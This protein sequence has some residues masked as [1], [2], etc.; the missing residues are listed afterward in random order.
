M[1]FEVEEGNFSE[2][3]FYITYSPETS[4]F[5]RKRNLY[6]TPVSTGFPLMSLTRIIFACY[7]YDKTWNC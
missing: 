3:H 6:V 7:C 4:I 1:T 2:I 5:P